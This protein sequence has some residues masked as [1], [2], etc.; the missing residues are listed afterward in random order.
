MKTSLIAS[1]LLVAGGAALVAQQVP[2]NNL[3]LVT[4][5][6]TP[7]I[8]DSTARG[9]SG[10]RIA[11]PRFRVVPLKGLR[12]PYGLAFLPDGR[13]LVTERAG[14]I[15]IVKD[16]KLDPQ[17]IA[18]V[19]AVLDRNLRGMND[20][21]LHPR[22]AENGLIYFTYFKPV[23]ND[24]SAAAAV[25]ARGKFDGDH[26]LT[27]VKELLVTDTLVTGPSAARMV[28]ARDGKLFLAIG[29][30]IPPRPKAGI[31]AP[32]DAQSPSSL[33]GKILRLNDDGTAAKDNPF[34]GKQGYRPEIYA[35]GIRNA[36]GLAI[37][38]ETG[39]LWE[40]ENGPQGGDE[41]NIIRAGKNYGWPV[42]SYGRSYGGDLTGDTGP[43]LALP[44]ANGME[45]PYLFWSPSIAL[46]GLTFYT[47]DK[48]PQ[49]RGSVFVGGL[50]GEQ[51]QKITMNQ[52]GLPI[53]RDPL[54]RELQQ[55]IRDVQ[56][57]PDGLLY[58]LTD[59]ADGA[60]LR[61]EPVT[62][63]TNNQ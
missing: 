50:V 41:L 25:L 34:V 8:F 39:E 36:M 21:V 43:D 10:A 6:D 61:I 16:G 35:L 53:R 20:I 26:A 59:E 7:Q 48:F 11:G 63:S 45:Q 56:Q 38:P 57:G 32:K 28:F 33:W 60:M 22:F 15:R 13:I 24:E 62:G 58:V 29:I 42:I 30:P 5:P 46:S 12:Y 55:R 14:R 54:L 9:P 27:D 17:P 51:L 18:G 44:V 31:A 47:G 52:R 40:T 1:L 23:P 2:Q 49:W 37:H 4:L 3:P 19:P